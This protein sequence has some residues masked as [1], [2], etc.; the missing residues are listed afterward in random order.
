MKLKLVA[1]P[2]LVV[3]FYLSGSQAETFTVCRQDSRI[4]EYIASA[5]GFCPRIILPE[6]IFTTFANEN[7]NNAKLW[8]S[9]WV[10]HVR[11]SYPVVV[12]YSTNCD[13][14]GGG[15][16]LVYKFEFEANELREDVKVTNT[17]LYFF[18]STVQKGDGKTKGGE[19]W[20][21]FQCIDYKFIKEVKGEDG[22]A[23]DFS[24]V[25]Q[26]KPP[27]MLQVPDDKVRDAVNDL[28]ANPKGF[29]LGSYVFKRKTESTPV[30]QTD[31]PAIIVKVNPVPMVV[32]FTAKKVELEPPQQVVLVEGP[33]VEKSILVD[34]NDNQKK[35][36]QQQKL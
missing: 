1:I 5:W 12:S 29:D 25:K 28:I 26:G 2:L 36:T 4:P 22:K 24:K 14:T 10:G 27:R 19:E 15:K 18:R 21:S 7:M 13:D 16:G 31:K 33:I 8:K 17:G 9:W 30:K 32:T 11:A 23:V 3:L 6:N 20:D 35:P 34:N